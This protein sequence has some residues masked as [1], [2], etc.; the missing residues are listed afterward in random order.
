MI[1]FER[2]GDEQRL[3][4]VVPRLT[5]ALGFAPVG[6]TWNDNF[7]E[8]EGGAPASWLDLLTGRTVPSG[9]ERLSLSAALSHFPFAVLHATGAA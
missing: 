8:L 6:E 1:A 3:L 7:L 9:H 5:Y 4:V 2:R